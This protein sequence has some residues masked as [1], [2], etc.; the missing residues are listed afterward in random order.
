[1]DYNNLTIKKENVTIQCGQNFNIFVKIQI[2]LNVK[3]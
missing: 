2:T 1:M 3:N